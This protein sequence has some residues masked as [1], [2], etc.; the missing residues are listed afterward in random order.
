M[1]VRVPEKEAARPRGSKESRSNTFP[2]SERAKT[3]PR[4]IDTLKVPLPAVSALKSCDFAAEKCGCFRGSKTAVHFSGK[5]LGLDSGGRGVGA[6]RRQRL[7]EQAVSPLMSARHV[8]LTLPPR[9][10]AAACV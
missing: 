10:A 2:R 1:L 8:T 5:V 9:S 6:K 7:V 4:S 3:D